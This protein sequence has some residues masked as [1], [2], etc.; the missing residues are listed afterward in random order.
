MFLLLAAS[1]LWGFA[2]EEGGTRFSWSSAIIVATLVLA[3]VCWIGFAGWEYHVDKSASLQEPI[4]LLR[5]LKN[6]ILVGMMVYVKTR[7]FAE[8]R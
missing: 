8:S 4:F 5:L 3:G 2:L 7:G 1:V 6:R